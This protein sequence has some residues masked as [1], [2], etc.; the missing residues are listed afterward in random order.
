MTIPDWEIELNGHI[1][2]FMVGD[3]WDEFVPFLI[4]KQMIAEREQ[5][6]ADL[7][8]EVAA[9]GKNDD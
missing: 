8:A 6:I 4:A 1:E 7:Q 2:I 5:R 3:G 9:M